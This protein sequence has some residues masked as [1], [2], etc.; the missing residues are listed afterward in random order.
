MI[1]FLDLQ[2]INA[3]YAAELKQV[4]AE[5]IDSGWFLMGEKLNSFESKLANYIGAKNAIGVA[6]GLDALRL[7]LK[8]YID[9][10]V[11]TEGD[12][13]IVPANT[14]IA[15]VLAITDNRLKPVLVEPKESCFNLDIDLIES[16]ITPK[17]KAIMVVH[18]YGQVCW[19]EKLAA[20]AKKYDL[21]VIEDNAQAIGAEWNGIKTGN[22]GDAAGF[23]FYPGKN[24]GALGDAGAVTTNDDALAK[25]IRALG[26]YGSNKKY[27]NEFQGLNSRLDEIQAA[28]LDVKIKYIDSENQY[29]KNIAASYLKGIQHPKI[30]LPFPENKQFEISE[31]AE[32][33]WHLFV[34]RCNEREKLQEYLTA[35]GIQTLIHYP[36]PPNKQLAYKEMNH[37]DFPITNTIH[38]EV[39][40]LP[41]SP[42]MDEAEIKMIIEVLNAYPA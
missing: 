16:H 2:K 25:H 26:N 1:K 30:K 41:I 36:I 18:L 5:V 8:A 15:S 39:L 27:V 4:A 19:N 34:I 29:R 14:Y 24:L 40:S 9:L 21:K 35:N 22:L 32:H 28:F 33:V 7:I 10:G 6:N 20:L 37:L 13:V 11:M 31:N 17:T 23:S 3:Q 38:N 42:V 12:E